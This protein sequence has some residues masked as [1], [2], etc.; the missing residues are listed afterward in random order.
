V[1]LKELKAL[2]WV[3]EL[4]RGMD[5]RRQ[6]GQEDRWHQ[7]EGFFYNVHPSQDRSAPN[8][9]MATGDALMSTL[10]V[11]YPHIG[12][13][14]KTPQAVGKVR[15]LETTD[16]SLLWDLDSPQTVERMILHA[17]LWGVGIGKIGY[18]SEFG[19]N[20]D[21]DVDPDSGM[22][23]TQ[24]DK[25]G[26]R[27]EFGNTHPGMPW[28][29][30]CLPHDIVVPWGTVSFKSAPWVA[31]R[32]VR[33]IDLLKS[34]PK[35]DNHKDLKP[36]MTMEDW[37]NS[38]KSVGK[39]H[40]IGENLLNSVS[41][42][43]DVKY[44]ELWEIHDSRTQKIY[45]IATGHNRYLRNERDLLQ[46]DE[47]LPFVELSFVPKARTFWTTSDASYLLTSQAELS[48]IALQGTKHRR[49]AVS[50]LLA[51][52]GAFSEEEMDKLMSSDVKTVSTVKQGFASSIRDAVISMEPS[53][54]ISNILMFEKEN[55]RRDARELVGFSRN[56]TGEFEQT[57]RRTA[58]EAAI[59]DRSSAMRMSRRQSR[60]RD[61]YVEAFKK[62]NEV[63]FEF[64]RTPRV[65]EIIGEMGA[66]DFVQF[67]GPQLKGDYSYEVS[68]S[69]EPLPNK[70][71][72]RQEALSM[73][74]ALREDPAVDQAQLRRFLANSF[75]D[76]EF[77]S[78]FK[79]GVLGAPLSPQMPQM[80]PP[81]GPM[82][83]DAGQ[84]PDA[85]MSQLRLQPGA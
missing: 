31:H 22:T 13:K 67:T 6:Y 66:A 25:K 11:P 15:A 50:K 19:Y 57:G 33:H 30:E 55:V 81:G 37:V 20:P 8:I 28:F 48:D 76:V 49:S 5:F 46:L 23:L 40:R 60:I 54:Q 12:V 39:P 1:P 43:G 58:T 69:S 79:S 29:Q 10:S 75:N 9:I 52:E 27:I 18:D 45:V 85:G 17:F 72:R 74:A 61:L 44:V 65:V 7:L 56:Q 38:Y 82:A 32:V 21:F 24:F 71:Q 51:M 36:T 14:A 80:Q 2:E 16:N 64:W 73:F 62:I 41:P 78:I 35:Y 83:G 47:G 59:V 63:I 77:S 68:F 4:D 42:M 84:Q 53:G 3:E 34:D 26:D 70:S